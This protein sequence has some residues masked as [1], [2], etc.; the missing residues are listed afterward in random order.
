VT[1][2]AIFE[3]DATAPSRLETPHVIVRTSEADDLLEAAKG[4][5]LEL[6]RIQLVYARALLAYAI[7]GDVLIAVTTMLIP[8]RNAQ[9]ICDAMGHA[10]A[11]VS[12]GRVRVLRID[13]YDPAVHAGAPP[14]AADGPALVADDS[15][16][17]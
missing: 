14:P 9:V 15:T 17:S 1:T 12:G 6:D 8:D 2:P 13:R 11:T 10:L 5:E 3:N 4:L 16:G 7:E